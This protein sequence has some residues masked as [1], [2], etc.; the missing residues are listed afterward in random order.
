MKNLLLLCSVGLVACGGGGTTDG[1]VDA[2]APDAGSTS[3]SLSGARTTTLIGATPVANWSVQPNRGEVS[4]TANGS[5]DNT[6]FSFFFDGPPTVGTLVGND[7]GVDCSIMVTLPPSL[8]GWLANRG[9]G[10]PDL[11]TCSLTLS[12]V[13]E[14]ADVGTQKRYT[15]HGTVGGT[16]PARSGAATGTVTF[17]ASF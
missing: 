17:S 11:G 7:A 10:L 12:S 16:L 8:D 13:T 14:K 5:P 15:I 4:L 1:G 9:S 3:V 2:G 6:S